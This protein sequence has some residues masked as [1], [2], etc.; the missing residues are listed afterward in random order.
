MYP[1]IDAYRLPPADGGPEILPWENRA[2]RRGARAVLRF[3]L[4]P[5]APGAVVVQRAPPP[6]AEQAGGGAPGWLARLIRRVAP[7]PAR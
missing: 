2:P 4:P 1:P 5:A 7:A 3:E 6:V